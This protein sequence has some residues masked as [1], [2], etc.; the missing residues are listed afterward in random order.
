MGL[1][2]STTTSSEDTVRLYQPRTAPSR[3]AEVLLRLAA[4]ATG[5][6]VLALGLIAASS[7]LNAADRAWASVI[8]LSAIMAVA[9]FLGQTRA[10][11]NKTRASAEVLAESI[12]A[13]LRRDREEIKMRLE[14]LTGALMEETAELRIASQRAT[15]ER[16]AGRASLVELESAVRQMSSGLAGLPRRGEV[17]KLGE[18]VETLAEIV[19]NPDRI[20]LAMPDGDV[21]E[22]GRQTGIEE[23]RRKGHDQ[24]P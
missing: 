6:L 21:F 20:V 10:E 2:P 12:R 22:I 15:R 7:T 13:E 17:E 24:T 9:A 5:A 1:S 11:H 18:Q 19:S 3:G 16:A 23:E 14:S 4:G 8:G